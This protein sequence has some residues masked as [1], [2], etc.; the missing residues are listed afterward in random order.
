MANPE[1]DIPESPQVGIIHPKRCRVFLHLNQPELGSLV[2]HNPEK[3]SFP[4]IVANCAAER[5]R[6]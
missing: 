5:R 1:E 4:L 2:E 6:R 3:E